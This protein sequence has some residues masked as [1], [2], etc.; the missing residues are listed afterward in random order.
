VRISGIHAPHRR[1]CPAA[2]FVYQAPTPQWPDRD[3]PGHLAAIACIAKAL[4]LTTPI[5]SH[6][7]ALNFAATA[8]G[9]LLDNIHYSKANC[10]GVGNS[11]NFM[12]VKTQLLTEFADV[13]KVRGLIAD[14]Q[15]PIGDSDPLAQ[16]ALQKIIS[17]IQTDVNASD[18][19][20]TSGD[21]SDIAINVLFAAGLIPDVGAGFALSATMM[22]VAQATANNPNGSPELANFQTTANQLGIELA[23]QYVAARDQMGHIGDILVSDWGKLST[24]AQ[25]ND[26]PWQWTSQDSNN[27]AYALSAATVSWAYQTLFP[28]IYSLYRFGDQNVQYAG[29]YSCFGVQPPAPFAPFAD[30]PGGGETVVTAAGSNPDIWSFGKADQQFLQENPHYRT[31]GMVPQ[32]LWDDMFANPATQG[33]S[34]PPFPS[35]LAFMLDTYGTPPDVV[36]HASDGTCLINDQPPP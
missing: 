35:E 8:E 2:Q 9:T 30:A 21:G 14:W 7:L 27:D 22:Q 25:N 12:D 4:G 17:D 29:Q 28:T 6:Y 1:G 33:G 23:Q 34:A 36:T 19:S 26:G 16:A 31:P 20:Q 5:E 18:G 3:T 13:A 32:S 11:T 24:A 10:P 15:S